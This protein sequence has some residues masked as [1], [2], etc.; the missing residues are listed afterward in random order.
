MC[1]A[2]RDVPL[3]TFAL[4]TATMPGGLNA[5][6]LS[7]TASG[8]VLEVNEVGDTIVIDSAL[9]GVAAA[10]NLLAAFG[11]LRG[12]GVAASEA[13]VVLGQVSAAP[14]RMQMVGGAGRPKVVIDYSHTP[15]ALAGAL[16]ALAGICEGTLW[17]VFGAGGDRDPGKRPLMGEAAAR[18]ASRLVVT[19]D[20]PRGESGDDIIDRIV[21]G[22]PAASR[23]SVFIERDRGRAIAHAI[24]SAASDDI[25]LVAGKG[26]ETYQEVA[27]ERRPFS[28]VAAARAA[29]AEHWS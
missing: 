2:A 14:G 1:E 13:A 8:V 15:A 17:C 28:D 16:E 5:R 21:D 4:D 27:G 3:T 19:D 18:F 29:L 23:H 22:V 25:I 11:V 9:I 7:S 10:W 6:L 26:H 20:N 24:A 12:L